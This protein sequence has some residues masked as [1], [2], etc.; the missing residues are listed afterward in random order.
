MGNLSLSRFYVCISYNFSKKKTNSENRIREG[1][2]GESVKIRIT[3]VDKAR[4]DLWSILGVIMS[5][6]FYDE[7]GIFLFFIML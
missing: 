6:N 5:G 1:K 4:S 7:L 3:D 2:I